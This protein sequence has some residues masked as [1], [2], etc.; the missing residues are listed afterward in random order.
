MSREQDGVTGT[1][2]RGVGGG[3]RRRGRDWTRRVDRGEGGGNA[4]S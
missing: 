4:G 3:G 1:R 2:G